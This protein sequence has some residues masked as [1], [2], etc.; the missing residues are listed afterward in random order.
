MCLQRHAPKYI[1]YRCR[2][3]IPVADLEAVFHEQLK[4]FFF[5]PADIAGYLGEADRTIKDKQEL[6]ETLSEESR[7]LKR[8]MDKL[9]NLYMADE[10]TREGFGTRYRP[11]EERHKQLDDEMP[12]LQAEIDFLKV[13]YLA[14]D[15]ILNEAKDLYARWPELDQTEK[16]KVVENITEKIVV[17]K[18]DVAIN[19]C[20]LP[21]ASE[22]MAGKQRNF[23][24]S[25]PPP[26]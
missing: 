3:K 2:N 14:S 18:D 25:W 8:E 15:E 23:R 12:R 13:Q 4:N 11:L 1:C 17:G 20:Y 24:G 19:L 9:Y 21:S 22:M 6:L 16:R 5:S 10:I 26:S 7:K